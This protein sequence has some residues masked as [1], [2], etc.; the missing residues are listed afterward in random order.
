MVLRRLLL[1]PRFF[2]SVLHQ[3]THSGP[4]RPGNLQYVN[5]SVKERSR[6]SARIFPRRPMERCGEDIMRSERESKKARAVN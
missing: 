5:K 1:S 6:K 2:D 4:R 3:M